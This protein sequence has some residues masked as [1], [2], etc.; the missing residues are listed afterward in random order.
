MPSRPL[1]ITLFG[2]VI[3]C[4][5][6]ALLAGDRQR[7]EILSSLDGT[8]QPCYVIPPN[9]FQLDGP[10]VPLLISLHTWSSSVE[11]RLKG[12]ERAANQRG[13]IYLFPHFRGPN[14]SPDACGSP[15][16][17]QDILDALDWA[18]DNYPVDT[19]RVYL[20]GVS[21]GGHM[22]M[23]MAGRYPQRFSAV[24][25]WV[26]ISDLAAWH[27]RHKAGRYG[28]M[29]RA[30]CSGAPGD[31]ARVDAQYRLRSPITWL[32]GAVEVPLDLAAGVHDGHKGSVPVRH[33][34]EAFNVVARA[35]NGPTVTEKEI[36]QISRSDGRLQNPQP[37]DT[38]DDPDYDRPIYL[39]RQA[40]NC[41]VTIFEGGHER[42]D[43]SAARWL[44]RQVRPTAQP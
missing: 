36:Q 11:Q 41:R 25:A 18:L 31:N 24:S 7:V 28:Q 14:Q 1:P 32:A 17:Q 10:P 38:I 3:L 35:Q 37:C 34:L 9:D 16:A 29:C 5:T 4:G 23:L 20:T 19:R 22:A 6:S 42:L 33:T 26:G 30:S 13:W 43:E 8:K 21:G 40:G 39:R 2:L 12:M 27:E 44:A 15:K